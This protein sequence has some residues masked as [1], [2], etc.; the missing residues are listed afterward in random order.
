MA[1]IFKRLFT[2]GKSEA[3]NAIDKM[4]DPVKMAKQVIRDLEGQL[5]KALESL[6]KMKS[7]DNRLGAAVEKSKNS[8]KEWTE[9]AE[10]LRDRYKAETSEEKKEQLKQAMITS[11][12]KV[13]NFK[14]DATSQA[15]KYETQKAKTQKVDG[16]IKKLKEQIAGY[17][18]DMTQLEADAEMAKTSKAVAKEMSSVNTDSATNIMER[19]KKKVE[20][21][22][23]E[24]EAY[25]ELEDDNITDADRVDALLNESSPTADDK[26]LGD[27]LNE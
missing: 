3:N 9:K 7:L 26:L 14:L 24:A 21:D 11:L 19:M 25:M 8:Q 15:K 1:N 20:A 27:F 5:S 10:Q 4:E 22:E 12:N 18:S 6:A 16:Q 17:K 23:F 2:V 13:E